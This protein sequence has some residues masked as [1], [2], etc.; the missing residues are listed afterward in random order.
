M[1]IGPQLQRRHQIPYHERIRER[2]ARLKK[3]IA[4][5]KLYGF[6]N[7]NDLAHALNISKGT[8]RKDIISLRGAGYIIRS[9]RGYGYLFKGG[10]AGEI[11]PYREPEPRSF[12]AEANA[13]RQRIAAFIHEN[14]T[15]T[16]QDLAA[17]FHKTERTIYRDIAALKSA[18]FPIVGEAYRGYSIEG[19][20]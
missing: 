7:G 10:T 17:S 19:N 12:K 11:K 2:R 16:A 9:G 1:L 4:I 15:T 14:R 18:G 3:L 5:F 8:L 20:A 6:A 13:R